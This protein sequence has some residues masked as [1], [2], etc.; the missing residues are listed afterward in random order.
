[1]AAV[2][3]VGDDRRSRADVR[4]APERVTSRLRRTLLNINSVRPQ[5]ASRTGSETVGT[6][7][8]STDVPT[9]AKRKDVP[10]RD[11]M[12]PDDP[13]AGEVVAT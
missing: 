12:I 7:D 6:Q 13:S 8:N 2:A 10:S 9:I 1:M 3:A 11:F 5:M 4:S